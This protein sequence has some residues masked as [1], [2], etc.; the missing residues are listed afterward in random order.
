M[1]GKLQILF[2]QFLLIVCFA[3]K[4]KDAKNTSGTNHSLK[5]GSDAFAANYGDFI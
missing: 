4:N 5:F 1:I 3:C 2:F